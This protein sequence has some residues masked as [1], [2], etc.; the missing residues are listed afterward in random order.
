MGSKGFIS[1][2]CVD[3]LI[4][5]CDTMHEPSCVQPSLALFLSVN[6]VGLYCDR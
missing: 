3:V 1:V 4:E 2:A 6:V 5:K